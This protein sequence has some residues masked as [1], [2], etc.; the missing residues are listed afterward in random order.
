MFGTNFDKHRAL[1]LSL[2]L[3]PMEGR[4]DLK[5][6]YAGKLRGKTGKIPSPW[7]RRN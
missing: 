1:S 4:K 5:P 3:S 6:K 2:C 7:S